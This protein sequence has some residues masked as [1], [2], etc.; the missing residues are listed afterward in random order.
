LSD[1]PLPLDQQLDSLMI[2][3]EAASEKLDEL[4]AERAELYRRI[5]FLLGAVGRR[6]PCTV[7]AIEIYEVLPIDG[8]PE[9]LSFNLDSNLHPCTPGYAKVNPLLKGNI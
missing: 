1:A 7:C 4:R 9:T 8:V 5:G 6:K 2:A 3:I